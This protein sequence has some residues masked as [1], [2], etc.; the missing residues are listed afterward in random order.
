MKLQFDNSL[1]NS[2]SEQDHENEVFLKKQ[3]TKYT[4]KRINILFFILFIIVI[5]LQI[6]L[7]LNFVLI[8]NYIK[9][10]DVDE[11]NSDL[12]IIGRLKNIDIDQINKDISLI[13]NLEDFD[14]NEVKEYFNKTKIILDYVCSNYI[15]C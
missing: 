7:V 9:T 1:I 13:E 15:K 6:F 10:I 11:I 14:V 5:L 8:G 3:E 4:N 12:K 2:D